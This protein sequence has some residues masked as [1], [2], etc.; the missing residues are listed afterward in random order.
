MKK[1]ISFL[2]C[3]AMLLSFVSVFADEVTAETAEALAE[4]MSNKVVVEFKMIPRM[5]VVDSFAKVKLSTEDGTVLGEKVEWVGGITKEITFQFDV[6]EYKLGESFVLTLQDGVEYIK[7]YDDVFRKNDTVKLDTYGFVDENGEYV[8]GDKFSF[9]ACPMYDKG[10]VLYVEGR[11]VKLSPYGRLIDDVTMVPVRPV[12]EAMGLDVRYDEKYNSVV[13][14][15]GDKQAIFN[16]GL[17]YATLLGKD[18]FMP[19]ECME[20]GDTVFVPVRSL[21]DA[22]GCE[23]SVPDF[24]D[25]LDI[26]IGKSE[27]IEEELMKVHVNKEGITSR[28]NWLVWVDKSDYRVRVYN[29]SQYKWRQV[30]AFPCA[31][32]APNTPTITG[33]YEYQY[34]AS[35]WTYPEYYVGPCLVFH[36]G[37]ALHSTLLRYNGTPYD[38]RV[39]IKLSHGCIRLHKEDI[40]WIDAHLPLKSRI[41]VTE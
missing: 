13:C 27:I 17:K 26:L 32:G 12:A 14:S 34:K 21:A 23:L 15:I 3:V 9:D 22:F 35:R 39:G 31:I 41:Y 5:V 8:K 40:E 30:A 16:V 20:I 36:G 4:G 24:D 18:T 29:G 19:K 2:L 11:P 38:D 10:I 7:Y 1:I 25:H 6:P 37:Y 28:T 33:S